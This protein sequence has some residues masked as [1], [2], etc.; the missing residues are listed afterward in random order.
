[1]RRLATLTLVLSLLA[2]DACGTRG[3]LTLPPVDK[4]VLTTTHADFLAALNP[5]DLNTTKEPAL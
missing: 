2:L 3:P 1:M 4:T 5:S